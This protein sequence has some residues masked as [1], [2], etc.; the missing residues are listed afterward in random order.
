MANDVEVLVAF[1]TGDGPDGNSLWHVFGGR[2]DVLI[3]HALEWT[4]VLFSSNT[5]HVS[6]SAG[7]KF[8]RSLSGAHNKFLDLKKDEDTLA[9]A[10][11]P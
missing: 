3:K 2:C 6:S 4:A 5:S 8:Q 7:C 1:C 9:A 10:K 11:L